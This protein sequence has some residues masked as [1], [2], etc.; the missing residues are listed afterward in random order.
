MVRQDRHLLDTD[1][2]LIERVLELW[3]RDAEQRR[4]KGVCDRHSD[5]IPIRRPSGRAS[6]YQAVKR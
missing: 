3:H 6:D 5:D 2:R 4:R 1:A